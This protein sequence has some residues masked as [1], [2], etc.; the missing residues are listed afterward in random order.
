MVETRNR[1]AWRMSEAIASLG[2]T[3]LRILEHA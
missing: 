1:E 2:K 3:A